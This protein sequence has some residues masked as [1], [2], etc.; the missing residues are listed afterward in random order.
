M[1]TAPPPRHRPAHTAAAC[2]V[3]HDGRLLLHDARTGR[4]TEAEAELPSAVVESGSSF[5]RAASAALA[6]RTRLRAP[7]EHLVYLA[8]L[9]AEGNR[10]TGAPARNLR[11]FGWRLPDRVAA[12]GAAPA[13]YRWVPLDRLGELGLDPAAFGRLR[14][15][16]TRLAT[17]AE[18]RPPPAAIERSAHR[19]IG[20]VPLL[21]RPEA[22]AAVVVLGPPAVGKSTLLGRCAAADGRIEHVPDVV[23][24]NRGP[25][26]DDHLT[27]YLLG[28]S[29]A[30][31]FCQ[32]ETL[33]LRV[34][35]NLRTGQTGILDQ[36]VHSSLAYAK[37]LYLNG[38]LTVQEYEAY[39][40][41]H[42]LVTAMLPPPT[43]VVHLTARTEVLMRRLRRRDRRLE[44][45]FTS[46]YVALVAQC[47]EDVAEDLAA[48]IPVHRIDAS[49][50]GPQEVLDRF[51]R[52]LP[53]QHPPL[54]GESPE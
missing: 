11:V 20:P 28:D 33:L 34:L 12:A 21:A 26:R 31:F 38:D 25:G 14:S 5:R 42:H 44:R 35:Q 51:R 23:P 10:R 50:L 4:E 16:G 37:A 43:A 2:L 47:F 48:R 32:L 9:Y 40:R 53:E 13:G 46:R 22:P 24:V 41:Y 1:L 15:L 45:S 19:L 36:D 7:A 6:G 29:S 18:E 8:E 3:L 52:L 39:Y 49:E 27:R 54:P 30:A 17:M